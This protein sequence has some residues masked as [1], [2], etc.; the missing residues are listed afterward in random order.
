MIAL[1]ILR[2]LDEN[3]NAGDTA[4]G[5]LQWWLFERTIVEEQ[6]ALDR[7]L[8]C[9]VDRN[10]IVAVQTLD[11]RRHYHLNAQQTE[12]IRRLISEAKPGEALGR[13]NS[14]SNNG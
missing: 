3:P 14:G 10:L 4:D 1:K 5:I 13:N 2:Y 12:E 7:A 6:E 8:D 11:A 9:L